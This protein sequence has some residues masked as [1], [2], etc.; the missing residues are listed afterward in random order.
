MPSGGASTHCRN[1]LPEG[2]RAS[3]ASASTATSV[4]LGMSGAASAGEGVWV[5]TDGGGGAT[6]RV[7]VGSETSAPA[8]ADGTGA[9][10]EIAG[11]EVGA[12]SATSVDEFGEAVCVGGGVRGS[13][14]ATVV[15]ATLTVGVGR[16][17]ADNGTPPE[18]GVVELA[19]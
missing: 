4:N 13:A 18:A 10:P 8:R 19:H 17:T 3:A 12:A 5:A 16:M 2:R 14:A 1:V 11:V 7:G 15:G 9:G 6:M